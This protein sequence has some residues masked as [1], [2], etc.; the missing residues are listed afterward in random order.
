MKPNTLKLLASALL[1]F[2]FAACGD[3]DSSSSNPNDANE[4]K[5]FYK[6]LTDYCYFM[7]KVGADRFIQSYFLFI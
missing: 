6:T 7:N 4:R 3:S 5:L 1:V 2:F